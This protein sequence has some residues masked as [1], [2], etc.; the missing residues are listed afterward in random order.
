MPL[1]CRRRPLLA[2]KPTSDAFLCS[3]LPRKPVRRMPTGT[4]HTVTPTCSERKKYTWRRTKNK[5]RSTPTPE[6]RGHVEY[7]ANA[8]DSPTRRAHRRRRLDADTPAETET[9]TPARTNIDRKENRHERTHAYC[10]AHT[11][12]A[13]TNV[14]AN[15]HSHTHTQ[16]EANPSIWL[17][18][19][20]R[21]ESAERP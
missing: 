3:A 8:P 13:H 1:S 9:R 15:T 17:S 5:Y 10:R 21:W 16:D 14:H 12:T 19:L 7:S 2:V 20:G 18:C 4:P 6:R 11:H